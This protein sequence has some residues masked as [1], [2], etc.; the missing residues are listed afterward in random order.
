MLTPDKGDQNQNDFLALFVRLKTMKQLD[1]IGCILK[2]ASYIKYTDLDD[3]DK[4]DCRIVWE[5]WQHKALQ[6]KADM[7]QPGKMLEKRMMYAMLHEERL[8]SIINGLKPKVRALQD[9][10][11]KTT[12][13]VTAAVAARLE[14]RHAGINAMPMHEDMSTPAGYETPMSSMHSM[15]SG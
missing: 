11:Y 12:H 2:R 9:M 7:L 15:H 5:Y 10:N 6:F 8:Q 1:V 13:S 14:R 4:A 3:R